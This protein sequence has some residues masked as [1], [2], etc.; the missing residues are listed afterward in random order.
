MVLAV[1]KKHHPVARVVARRLLGCS[2][3]LLGLLLG[4]LLGC[5]G[6][7]LGPTP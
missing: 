6:W 7:L 2:V 3:W 5:S 4:G 1:A